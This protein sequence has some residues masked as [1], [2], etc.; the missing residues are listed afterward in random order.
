MRLSSALLALALAG[1]TTVGPDYQRPEMALPGEYPEAAVQGEPSIPADWW[2]LFQDPQLNELVQSAFKYNADVRLAAARVQEAAGVLREAHALI[3]PD[4]STG[5]SST[6]SRVSEITIPPPLPPLERTTN[7]L[8]VSTTYELDFWGRYA[9]G[10]EAARAALLNSLLSRDTVLLTLAGATSQAYFAL[11]SL[12]AQLTVLDLVIQSR[13]ESLELAQARAKA[14]LASDL[15][16]YQAQSALSDAVVQRY[17]TERSRQLVERQ[18][19]QLTG[20]LDLRVGAG[21]VFTLPLP[22]VPPAGLPSALL[23]RRPDVRA[24]EQSLVAANAQIGIAKAALFPSISLTAAAGSQSAEFA[25]LLSKGAGIWTLGAS[26]VMPIFDAG[27]RSA[28]VDQATARRE[29]AVAGYQRSVE[30]AFH[31]VADAL[32]NVDRTAGSETELQIRLKAAR[33]ALDLSNERYKAGYSPF[34]EVLDAQR[35]VNDA[36]IAFVRNRQARLAFSVDLMKALGG[37]WTEQSLKN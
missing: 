28:R 5:V 15:D 18:L 37:G 11:R 7:Q 30:T 31:E 29:Q 3:Y 23:E 20:R 22:P 27:R 12:D 34:L 17:D 25:D 14:G 33:A 13:R 16:V 24:A 4:V 6:R 9:R 35:T 26:V 36:A 1:C 19:A 2:T 21:D 10:D 8:L 32:V